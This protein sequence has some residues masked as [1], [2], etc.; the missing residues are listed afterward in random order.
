MAVAVKKPED[1]LALRA[2]TPSYMCPLSA[3]KYGVE[4]LKFSVADHDSKQKVFEVREMRS[5]CVCV[6][7]R[8]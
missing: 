2:P 7:A 5:A 4:F 3:N 6:R 8:A 1:A